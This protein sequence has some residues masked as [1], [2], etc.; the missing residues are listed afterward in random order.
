MTTLQNLIPILEEKTEN[1]MKSLEY[2]SLEH[3]HIY[4][5]ITTSGNFYTNYGG[6]YGNLTNRKA[7]V[8]YDQTIREQSKKY[9]VSNVLL[10]DETYFKT[11]ARKYLDW[12]IKDGIAS[13]CIITKNV[14]DVLNG[15]TLINGMHHSGP[16]I[17]IALMGIRMVLSVPESIVL[18][19][20]LSK[21]VDKNIAAFIIPWYYYKSKENIIINTNSFVNYEWVQ[22]FCSKHILHR[23]KNKILLKLP[24]FTNKPTWFPLNQIFGNDKDNNLYVQN[25][26]SLDNRDYWIRRPDL[27]E[28]S[29]HKKLNS[30][31]KPIK[32]NKDVLYYQ[33]SEGL[34]KY[35]AEEFVKLNYYEG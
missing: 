4:P 13:D 8:I 21:Y 16:E 3:S 32:Y 30:L 11:Y 2:K 18:W 20:R 23:L 22:G 27:S 10:K 35:L 17:I 5:Y 29:G 1:W 25:N 12:W 31:Y 26:Y 33:A 7:A 24:S 14:D 15:K 19:S 6:C 34:I 9:Y 28:I